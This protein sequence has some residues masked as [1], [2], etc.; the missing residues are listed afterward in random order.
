LRA[1]LELDPGH[2]E[3]RH[4]LDLLLRERGRQSA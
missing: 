3:A 2:K 4:N 1:V